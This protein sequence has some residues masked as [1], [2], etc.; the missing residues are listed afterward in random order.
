[1]AIAVDLARHAGRV[2]GEDF[3]VRV[4]DVGVVEVDGDGEIGREAGGQRLDGV[5]VAVDAGERAVGGDED[6]P[7]VDGEAAGGER[8]HRLRPAAG[9]GD[10][11][12]PAWIAVVKR[13]VG[14]DEIGDEGGVG[15][16]AGAVVGEA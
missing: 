2:D 10:A 12:Q 5:G 6:V 8:G 13:A 16:D 14:D 9:G 11:P 1:A 3:A 4:D 7:G 15:D